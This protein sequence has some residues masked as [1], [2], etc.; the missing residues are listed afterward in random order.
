[1]ADHLKA[2]DLDIIKEIIKITSD[3]KDCYADLNLLEL[4]EK[5]R[6]KVFNKKINQL[7]ELIK[8]ED[9]FYHNFNNIDKIKEA[10]NYLKDIIEVPNKDY[11]LML[12]SYEDMKLVGERIYNNLVRKIDFL[13]LSISKPPFFQEERLNY[14]YNKDR[15]PISI[16]IGDKVLADEIDSQLYFIHNEYFTIALSEII[17]NPMYTSFQSKLI[18]AKYNLAFTDKRVEKAIIPMKYNFSRQTIV[19]ERDNKYGDFFQYNDI[20]SQ[21]LYLL[22]AQ[23]IHKLLSLKDKEYKNEDQR[24]TFVLT[25]LSFKAKLM[26]ADSEAIMT[27][28]LYFKEYTEKNNLVGNNYAYLQIENAFSHFKKNKVKQLNKYPVL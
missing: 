19:F 9:I 13:N 15:G 2:E 5:T 6:T 23:D 12:T 11:I 27:A 1:M 22:L 24:P 7:K 21:R 16:K 28:Y 4:K 18:R 20:K 14:I 17:N 10:I 8:I 3:I 26:F 25:L